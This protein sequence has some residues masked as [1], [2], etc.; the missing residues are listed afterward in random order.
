MNEV[1]ISKLNELS[2]KVESL[3]RQ[4]YDIKYCRALSSEFGGPRHLN[5]NKSR[6]RK[7]GR[8]AKIGQNIC[9]KCK[10][11]GK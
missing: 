4:L 8:M 1:I 2:A 5:D 11:G 6:C 7:C 9:G 10:G 3:E